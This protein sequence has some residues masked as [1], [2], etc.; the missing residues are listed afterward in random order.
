MTPPRLPSFDVNTLTG[1]TPLY[2]RRG[3]LTPEEIA[4]SDDHF[5]HMAHSVRSLDDSVATLLQ[6]VGDR[7]D[8]T[9]VIYLSDNGF[10][11]GEHRRFGKN[12]A[13]GRVRA[14][15]HGRP[16]PALLP[17]SQSYVTDALVQNVDVASTIADVAGIPW[18]AD[19]H[20]LA[21]LLTRDRN[22][23]RS[24]ALIERCRADTRGQP[25]CSGTSFDGDTTWPSGYQGVV[26]ERFKYVE[27]DDGTRQLIDLKKD[28]ARARQPHRCPTVPSDDRSAPC[29]TPDIDGTE[30]PDHDRHRAAGGI[31]VES[32]GLHVLLAVAILDVSLPTHAG[33]ASEPVAAV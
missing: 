8:N 12:D 28:P 25:L 20:S 33:R 16:Y 10:L 22:S 19:G 1:G 32:P 21:P 26:T 15:P 9:I 2:A 6:A 3:P 30:C 14:G 27:Y 29:A 7:A 4:T 31:A 24:G 23:V 13:S 5:V 18:A 11:Y 17:G